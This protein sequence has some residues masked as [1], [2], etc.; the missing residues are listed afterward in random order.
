[1]QNWNTLSWPTLDLLW[2]YCILT[3]FHWSLTKKGGETHHNICCQDV[4]RF[5]SYY[6]VFSGRT[7]GESVLLCS[8]FSASSQVS[9]KVGFIIIMTI[10]QMRKVKIIKLEKCSHNYS[11]SKWWNQ[12]SKSRFF[13]IHKLRFQN[14]NCISEITCISVSLT[15]YVHLGKWLHLF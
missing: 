9:H 8:F 14:F 5:S 12:H 10:W 2:W 7:L 3:S 11:A 1:M 4:I 15:Q 13:Q 6:G